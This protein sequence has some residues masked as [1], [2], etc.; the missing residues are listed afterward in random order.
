MARIPSIQCRPI[1]VVLFLASSGL[2]SAFQST[3]AATRIPGRPSQAF[4]T[5]SSKYSRFDSITKIGSLWQHTDANHGTESRIVGR[6]SA[7]WRT[8]KQACGQRIR[9]KTDEHQT[10]SIP[11]QGGRIRAGGSSTRQRLLSM[12]GVM[13]ATLLV[14][15]VKVLAMG[16]GMGGAKGPVVPMSQ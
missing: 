9:E 10:P 14:R 1:V 11:I 15:P 13:F 3:P 5:T 8:F 6:F 2:I 16:G 4:R 7:K 12:V